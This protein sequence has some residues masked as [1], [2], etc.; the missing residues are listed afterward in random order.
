MTPARPGG[1]RLSSAMGAVRLEDLRSFVVLIETLSYREAAGL[2]FVTP[3]CLSRRISHLETAVGAQLVRTT[4]RSVAVTPA[5]AAF[6]GVARD[7][8][9]RLGELPACA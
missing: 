5:G 9:A 8:L 7:V 6:E 3:G 2:L 1:D 4:T